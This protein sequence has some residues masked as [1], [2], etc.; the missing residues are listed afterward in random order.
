MQAYKQTLKKRINLMYIPILL[1]LLLA[2]YDLFFAGPSIQN[3]HIADFQ[4]GM[5][6]GITMCAMVL[7]VRYSAIL[8][9]EKK[10]ALEYN[11]ENDERLKAVRAKAG[12]P[13]ILIT[14]LAMVFAGIVASY[15]N[16]TVALTLLAAA[17]V[18]LIVGVIVK[19]I[20]LKTM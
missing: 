8:K 7:I 17:T 6:T 11:K 3:S 4:L 2:T 9:D 19:T 20:Y 12:M 16:T 13:M 10:L 1:C 18:Q 5:L 15:F 14:A